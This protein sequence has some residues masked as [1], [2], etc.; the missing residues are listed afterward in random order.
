MISKETPIMR[1]SRDH[2]LR[3]GF[4]IITLLLVAFSS[5]SCGE[6]RGKNSSKRVEL[7]VVF[8]SDLL[9]LIRSCGC[10][11]KDN[12]GLGR[13]ATYIEKMRESYPN[14]IV[15]DAGDAMS[16]DLSYSQDEADLTWDALAL[17]ETDAFT[18]G[19]IDF[20]YGL[21][22]LKSVV[23]KTGLDMLAAN[24]VDAETG[25]PVFGSLYKIVEIE[26]GLKV[27]ITGVLDDTIRFPGYID[28]SSFRVEPVQKTLKMV[29]PKLKQEADFLIL[30]SH[31][32]RER[33]IELAARN[34]DFDLV[35][36]GHGKPLIKQLVQEGKTIV[37]ATGM[38]QYLGKIE[39]TLDGSGDYL[40]GSYSLITLEAEIEVHPRIKDLFD[41]YGLELTE[42]EEKKRKH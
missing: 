17:M 22:Y 36:V 32:G 25:E 28:Q 20:I 11:V 33:S 15:L 30:L 42:K 31:L 35:I 3:N 34:P 13:R 38:G 39:L 19:E 12:G 16:L 6:N 23:D 4:L 26:G 27:G 5:F 40:V 37:A 8:S 10:A 1:G 21:P 14:L 9:G 7:A 24:I 41:Y 29:L 2:L 18:P